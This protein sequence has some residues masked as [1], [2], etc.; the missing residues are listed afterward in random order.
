MGGPA[1]PG[2]GPPSGSPADITKVFPISQDLVK[3]ALLQVREGIIREYGNVPVDRLEGLYGPLF[4]KVFYAIKHNCLPI[5]T[6]NYDL[7]IERYCDIAP[8]PTLSL[9]RGFRQR[10]IS[11]NLHWSRT[12]FDEYARPGEER[13]IVLFKL[14][15][16]ADWVTEKGSGEISITP[17]V[18]HTDTRYENTVIYPATRKVAIEEPYS[19]AYD[20]FQRCSEHAKVCVTI[21]YSFRDYD[22]LTRF[23]SAARLNPDLKVLLI[24]PRAS[25]LKLKLGERVNCECVDQPFDAAKGYEAALTSVLPSVSA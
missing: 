3:R 16:S 10:P 2:E 14:H 22:M 1:L 24:S 4:A 23:R 13:S 6:T 18:L 9:V 7:A 8:S 5:F 25:E 19:T 20:Y 17:P 21:G 12:V 11:R 15:G